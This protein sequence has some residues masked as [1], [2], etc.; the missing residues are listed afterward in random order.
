[1][2]A[3]QMYHGLILQSIGGF[4]YVETAD[5]VF[6]CKAR[7]T[8]RKER[9]SPLSGDRVTV[10][11]NADGTGVV[12]EILPRRNSLVRPPIANVDQ[13]AIVASVAEPKP[14]VLLLDKLI[15]IAEDNAIQP[16]VVITKSDLEDTAAL[17]AIY[18]MAGFPVFAVT[19]TETESAAALKDVLTG[20][21][22]AFTG[23]S[24]VGKS[25][26]LNLIDP[27]LCRETGEISKK[28][29]R[30]RHTTRS[31]TLFPLSGGGYLADTPGFSALDIERTQ[32]ID[33]EALFDCFREFE[34]YFGKCRF[35]GC[36]HVHEPDCAVRAAV[37]AG[38]IARSRFDS[39]VA[40]Y[41]EA[42]L[43]KP[44]ETQG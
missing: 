20:K 1:M 16:L 29:G 39:Y 4:Y 27:A 33:K 23:N 32:P 24:G 43:R 30:G 2:M 21:I 5:G 12:E 9:V 31:V 19:N 25:S 38:E 10:T 13:L 11:V 8:F 7:G 37:E 6:E 17:E 22:T 41:E 40:M 15:A 34:P 44:W 3:D 26:L 36:S 28:L 35:T 18:R 14:N 42:K